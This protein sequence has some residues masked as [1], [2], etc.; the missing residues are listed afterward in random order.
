MAYSSQYYDPQKAH[1]YY[2][3]HKK[4]K[5]RTST[6]GLNDAGKIAAKEVKE[7]IT[8]ERKAQIEAVKEKT[9]ENIDNIKNQMQGKIDSLRAQLKG[10]SKEQRA[11]KKE[12]IMAQIA[13]LREESKAARQKIK[14]ESSA[15][16][17]QIKEAADEKYAQEL[18]KINSSSE[19]QKAKKSK[20]KK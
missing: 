20:K 8:E 17:K 5:G 4:L 6:A 15:V 19:F 7:Q 9:K 13:G 3:K 16:R 14:D 18:E 10:M 12:E 1:E 11:A 2:E